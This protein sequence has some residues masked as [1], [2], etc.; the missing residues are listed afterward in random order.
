MEPTII[1]FISWSGARKQVSDVL[2]KQ[3]TSRGARCFGYAFYHQAILP[4]QEE[5]QLVP[6]PVLNKNIKTVTGGRKRFRG[7]LACDMLSLKLNCSVR[8]KPF[9][10]RLLRSK[11]WNAA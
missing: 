7:Y 6:P 3:S 2:E 1:K 4:E 9:K 8:R 10:M 5:R 11:D